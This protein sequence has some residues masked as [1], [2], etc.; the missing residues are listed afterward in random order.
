L[1]AERSHAPPFR[2]ADYEL[3]RRRRMPPRFAPLLSDAAIFDIAAAA[4]T[5][6]IFHFRRA[7]FRHSPPRFSRRRH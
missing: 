1:P 3:M 7:A 4:A 2:A 5:L 6:S